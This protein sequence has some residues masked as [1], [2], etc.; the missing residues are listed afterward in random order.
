MLF[1]KNF[2]QKKVSVFE[3]IKIFS[4]LFRS[5]EIIVAYS[6]KAEQFQVIHAYRMHMIKLQK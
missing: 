4:P 3:N 5:T 6:C 2:R 1:L